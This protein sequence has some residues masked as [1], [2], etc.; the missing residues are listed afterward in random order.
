[1]VCIRVYP[2]F[3]VPSNGHITV[4]HVY[5]SRGRVYNSSPVLR[6]GADLA[7]GKSTAQSATAGNAPSS[8]A[9]NG[10]TGTGAGECSQTPDGTPTAPAW[11]KVSQFIMVYPITDHAALLRR[12]LH[13]P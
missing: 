2:N 3:S 11:W 9:V 8:L 4:Q 12:G 1:M 5:T 6:A 7:Q 10:S 13:L